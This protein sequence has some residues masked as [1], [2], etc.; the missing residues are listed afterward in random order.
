MFDF[1]EV[2]KDIKGL[3]RTLGYIIFAGFVISA[4]TCFIGGFAS[5]SGPMILLMLLLAVVILVIGY[6]VS[7]VSVML[8]YGFGELIDNVMS[9]NE[10]VGK[11]ENKAADS[12]F[13][14]APKAAPS[15]P[16]VRPTNANQPQQAYDKIPTWKRVEMEKQKSA[17]ENLDQ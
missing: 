9:I 4:I 15:A 6:F 17:E 8:L 16:S 2:G 10:R 13:N 12:D 14:A 5:K 11:L 7:R 3:A 1:D